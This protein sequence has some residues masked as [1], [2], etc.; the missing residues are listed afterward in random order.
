MVRTTNSPRHRLVQG[1]HE[2][3]GVW[4]AVVKGAVGMARAAHF[5]RAVRLVCR[6]NPRCICR[7]EEANWCPRGCRCQ[8]RTAR[9]WGNT[10]VREASL[11]HHTGPKRS[12]RLVR[13]RCVTLT[14]DLWRRAG[15]WCR[16]G[17]GVREL[18]LPEDER[19]ALLFV[20]TYF[21][22]IVLSQTGSVCSSPQGGF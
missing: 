10:Q 19:Q 16:I 1:A 5:R 7:M 20:V 8:S 11:S 22:I 13:G 3:T 6:R 17:W 14:F 21:I 18:A 9:T 4:V 12:E 2:V 15:I